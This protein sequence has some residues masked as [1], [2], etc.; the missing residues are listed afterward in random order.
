MTAIGTT[1]H[2]DD[3]DHDHDHSRGSDGH[4]HATGA[5]RKA[6][7]IALSLTGGYML[8]QV[9][10]GIL[11]NSLALLADA[12][13]MLSDAGALAL[14]L[15]AMWIA[16]K[17][18]SPRR[19]FGFHRAEIL[20]ALLNGGTL[21]ALAIY[22][23]FEAVHRFQEPEPVASLPMLGVAFVGLLVNLIS[24][25]V[26]SRYSNH[27]LNIRGAFLHVM[28]DAL[29]SVGVIVAGVIIYFTGWYA[30]DAVASLIIAVL[31]IIAGWR[32]V[33]ETASIL[34]ESSPKGLDLLA[35]END[36]RQV[37]GVTEVHD[38]HV[39]TV[40]SGFVSLSAHLTIQTDASVADVVRESNH[41]LETNYGIRHVTIQPEFE[42]LHDDG[43]MCCVEDHAPTAA[44][45][46]RV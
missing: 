30:A 15:F 20:A 45:T 22:I 32:L 4:N 26:L 35:V 1:A 21:L 46:A 41:V 28:G 19:T 17:R 31:I 23:V 37:L 29:G 6:L 42:P 13:H 16:A 3:H 34:L 7:I 14:A 43:D 27:N 40:T 5:P 12:G 11:A 2:T 25:W 8:V 44:T 38:L 10:G 33:R 39:W 36:L 18:H 9:A 24:M